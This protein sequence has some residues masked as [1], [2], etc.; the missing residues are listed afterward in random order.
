MRIPPKVMAM[1]PLRPFAALAGAVGFLACASTDPTPIGTLRVTVTTTGADLPTDPFTY[2][3]DG[4]VARSIGING[5]GQRSDIPGGT[6]QVS[7]HGVPPNCTVADGAERS[8]EVT[9]SARAEVH[10]RVA[11]TAA[12]ATL[13]VRVEASGEPTPGTPYRITLDDGQIFLLAAGESVTATVAHTSARYV[14]LTQMPRNCHGPSLI[15]PVRLAPNADSTITIAVTCPRFGTGILYSRIREGDWAFRLYRAQPDGSM[16]VVVGSAWAHHHDGV[17]SPSGDLIAFTTSRYGLDGQA[18]AMLTPD[19]VR[20]RLVAGA[21]APPGYRHISKPS[22]S[23]DGRHVVA[24]ATRDDAAPEYVVFD[25]AT[26]EAT[27]LGVAAGGAP[28]WDRVSGRLAVLR[29]RDGVERVWLMDPDGANGRWLEDAPS[30]AY[31]DIAVA[32]SPDGTR[33]AVMRGFPWIDA[34]IVLDVVDVSS[35]ASERVLTELLSF[36][37]RPAWAPDGSQVLVTV[38]TPGYQAN[39]IEA[40]DLVTGVQTVVVPGTTASPSRSPAWR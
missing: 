29:R 7:L 26:G 40:V 5:S 9:G 6:R 12:N 16:E 14:G 21:T 36:E 23:P 8:V 20:E 22:W 39:Q 34:G 25:A 28:D 19:G 24:V 10:F 31:R 18:L 11:C 38:W 30:A 15:G 27:P 1:T 4:G 17:V 35:G 3:I 13:T 32:W 2:R 37:D 33:L